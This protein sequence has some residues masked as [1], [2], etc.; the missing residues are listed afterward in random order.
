MRKLILFTVLFLASIPMGRSCG[1]YPYGED[2][3]FS[4]LKPNLV[5]SSSTSYFYYNSKEYSQQYM[6]DDY[7]S[8]TYAENVE[9]WY[10]LL[11]GRA[12]RM[13]IFKAIYEVPSGELKQKGAQNS[14]IHA[15]NLAENKDILDYLLFAK[16]I[17][18][19]NGDLRD[20]WER[21][22][23][24][25]IA[26]RNKM[27]AKSIMNS[28]KTS[29]KELKRRYAHLAVRLAFYN[30]DKDKLNQLYTSYFDRTQ[31]NDPLDFW[32]LHFKV[33]LDKPS[34]QRN[35]DAALVFANSREK[36]L[37][38]SKKIDREFS[39]GQCLEHAKTEQEISALHYAFSV[40][41]IEPC[42][43]LLKSFSKNNSEEEK[44]LF[45]ALREINKLED[46]ILTPYFSS[47]E[48]TTRT[49]W[50]DSITG[51]I[52]MK[53]IMKD[54]S[55]AVQVSAWISE[56][57]KKNPNF[58]SRWWRTMELY[59]QFLA[60]N[61]EGLAQKIY[62]EKIDFPTDAQQTQFLEKLYVLTQIS[63]SPPKS[64]VEL[65]LAATI[66]K[67]KGDNQFLFSVGRSLEYAGSKTEAAIILSKVNAGEDYENSVTWKTQKRHRSLGSDY[68]WEY[69]YYMDAA[70]EVDEVEAVID[71]LNSTSDD[72]TF[73]EW[74]NQTVRKDLDRLYEL[75]GT[76]YVRTDELEKAL[77]A[78]LVIDPSFWKADKFVEYLSSDPFDN[79]FI[80]N[81]FAS[82]DR[83][84]TKPEIVE[85]LIKLKAQVAAY[86]GDEKAICAFRV[87]NCYRNM[88]YHGNSWLMRRYW[89][90]G[91]HR[92]AGYEDDKEYIQA[93][94]ARKYY[95]LAKEHATTEKFAA[96]SLRLAG[97]CEKYKLYD[98]IEDH[99]DYDDF[100]QY[101]FE[102]NKMYAQL[103]REFPEHYE[104][105]ISNCAKLYVYFDEVGK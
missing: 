10:I 2:V 46:W 47:F 99:W 95:M 39:L 6:P 57:K 80:S 105:L 104:P 51:K 48:P 65:G 42:I 81:D 5:F 78:F 16:S 88:T 94:L 27:I 49:T 34:P 102:R 97:T 52:L 40:K 98:E 103:K 67:Y 76:K 21:G 45:L 77:K 62:N 85:T 69:F 92:D 37:Q 71:Y 59:T 11:K 60:G 101:V 50:E 36:R 100:P 61:H 23:N 33:Q 29:S 63:N 86:T 4:M 38:A 25:M 53:R 43:E 72:S 3:R 73:D 9:L 41:S 44:H 91:Y 8:G 20:P 22:G 14:A 24:K 54:R 1:Y 18:S 12:S 58:S 13:D 19:L 30:K 68:Y 89:W 15:L 82:S 70:Y 26:T 56:L 7:S 90:S 93:N 83:S 28:H 74:K 96:L 55:Y 32:A 35:L 75:V 66:F 31:L 17:S 84:Y 64:M 79:N 87:A